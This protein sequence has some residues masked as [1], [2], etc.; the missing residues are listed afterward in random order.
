MR[1]V[2]ATNNRTQLRC[3]MRKD[4]LIHIKEL[5]IEKS[6]H[7]YSDATLGVIRL[8]VVYKGEGLYFQIGGEAV[9]CVVSA[10]DAMLS[11]K[12]IKKWD[13]GRNIDEA[14]RDQVAAVI[15]K[16]YKL[17]YKDDLTVV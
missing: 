2:K 5:K 6:A 4:E 14:E 1:F 11:K 12:S 7:E 13:S 17:A 10:R 8:L 9:I 15:A 16:Y 3:K